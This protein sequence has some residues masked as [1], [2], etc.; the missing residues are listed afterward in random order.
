MAGTAYL[1]V[2]V[3]LQACRAPSVLYCTALGHKHC[4][5]GGTCY[6]LSIATWQAKSE[7]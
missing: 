7:P 6:G 2:D 1:E 4:S 5:E 3:P